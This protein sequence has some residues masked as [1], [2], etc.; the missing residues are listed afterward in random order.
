MKNPVILVVDDD[1]AVTASLGLLLRKAGHE[2][3]LACGPD[4]ALAALGTGAVE[5]V[6][7]AMHLPRA[8][9]GAAGPG[10]LARPEQDHP[11][12]P[13]ALPPARARHP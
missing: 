4:E 3:V 5:L 2:T 9:S 12:P 13:A 6:P 8:T 1:E 7:Q 11:G 10:P